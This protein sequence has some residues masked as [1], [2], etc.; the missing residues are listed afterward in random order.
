MLRL[1][2]NAIS[3]LK[4]I[5]TWVVDAAGYKDDSNRVHASLKAI[6]EMNKQIQAER[7]YL[8][9]LT[10][11]MDYSTMCNELPN[12]YAPAYDGLKIKIEI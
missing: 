10:T 3:V 5:K 8:S 4:G 7:V 12:G 9:T 6:F 1:D 2:E 11:E